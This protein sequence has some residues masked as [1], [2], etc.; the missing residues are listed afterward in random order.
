M[1]DDDLD[2]EQDGNIENA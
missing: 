2:N 1:L